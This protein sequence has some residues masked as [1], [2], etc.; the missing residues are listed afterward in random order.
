MAHRPEE[1][2]RVAAAYALAVLLLAATAVLRVRA[3]VRRDAR[4]DPARPAAVRRPAGTGG[5]WSSSPY[6]LVGRVTRLR[7]LRGHPQTV[8]GLARLQRLGVLLGAVC[9][10]VVLRLGG[11]PWELP[12]AAVGALCVAAALITTGEVVQVCGIE[13]DRGCWE[14]LRQSPRPTGA[15]VAAKA[16]TASVA[17][18]ATTGPFCLGVA[19]LCGVH[20]P[21][22]WARVVLAHAVVALAA[23]WAVVLTYFC[24]PRSE[25]FAEG[26]ITGPRPPRSRRAC[27]S[28]SS[29]RRS[30]RAPR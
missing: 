18:A 10:G 29:P 4:T 14:A 3:T 30:P 25:A 24:V 17:V 26:R 27:S 19:A 5:A 11:P 15:W 23:G 12:F 2:G 13:A 9:L 21:A 1:A 22:G 7:F 28:R 20:G 8:G 6:V 16:V